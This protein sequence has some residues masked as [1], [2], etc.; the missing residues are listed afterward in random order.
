MDD[1]LNVVPVLK[2]HL[3]DLERTLMFVEGLLVSQDLQTEYRKMGTLNRPS[4][5]T[6]RVQQQ[7]ERILG[8]LNEDDE[9]G[10]PE[11]TDGVS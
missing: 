4:Q 1:G 9:D 7:R 10:R 2:G 3:A 11:W 5:L 6:K 8:Y